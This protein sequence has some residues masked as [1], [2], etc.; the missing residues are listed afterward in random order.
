MS[1]EEEHNGTR[2]DQLHFPGSGLTRVAILQ[3]D[4]SQAPQEGTRETACLIFRQQQL[5]FLRLVFF[6]LFTRWVESR[7]APSA[8]L[9]PSK[10]IRP[11]LSDL[12][13]NLDKKALSMVNGDKEILNLEDTVSFLVFK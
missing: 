8:S 7:H 9:S 10:P 12:N 5:D 4:A 11:R 6:H 3:A 1:E 13:Y 2:P